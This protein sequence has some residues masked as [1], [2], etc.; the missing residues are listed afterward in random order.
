MGRREI[1]TASLTERLI[2]LKIKIRI[3]QILNVIK[4]NKIKWPPHTV[5]QNSYKKWIASK[6]TVL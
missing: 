6:E 2:D 1:M 3:A 4:I 5:D